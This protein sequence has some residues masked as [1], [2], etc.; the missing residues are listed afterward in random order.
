MLE[1]KDRINNFL[2]F[3]EFHYFLLLMHY[4]E[5]LTWAYK[6]QMTGVFVGA[7]DTLVN[8]SNMNGKEN[9]GDIVLFAHQSPLRIAQNHGVYVLNERKELV[10]VLQKPTALQLEACEAFLS[11]DPTLS[12]TD[13]YY[14]IGAELM[15]ALIDLRQDEGEVH[16]E[17][18]CYGDFLRPLG[19][20]PKLGYL[21]LP[22]EKNRV[23]RWRSLLV[24]VFM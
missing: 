16:C 14:W 9:G 10:C 20:H 11:N 12:L 24:Y 1:L 4:S 7:A 18:C 8:F 22:D 2:T 19:N 17:L 23:Q 13:S 6:N 15:K 5:V 3:I 21:G